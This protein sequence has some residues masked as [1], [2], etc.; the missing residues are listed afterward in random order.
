M[1]DNVHVYP[2]FK[3]TSPNMTKDIHMSVTQK[4]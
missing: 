4:E 1:S 3:L 2:Q